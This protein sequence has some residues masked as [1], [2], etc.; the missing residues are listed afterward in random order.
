MRQFDERGSWDS[1]DGIYKKYTFDKYEWV[2]FK[3]Y[4]FNYGYQ[5]FIFKRSL[6]I[7]YKIFFLYIEDIKILLFCRG[8]D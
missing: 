8:Y 6:L 4:Q 3:N 7:E 5:R 2:E 1:F